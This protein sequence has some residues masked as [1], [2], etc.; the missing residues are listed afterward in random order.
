MNWR[1]PVLVLLAIALIGAGYI[2]LPYLGWSNSRTEA[3]ARVEAYL[4]A[5]VGGKEDRERRQLMT[6]CGVL[7]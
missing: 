1:A 4:V 7:L 5:V 6:L 2:Y 3:I